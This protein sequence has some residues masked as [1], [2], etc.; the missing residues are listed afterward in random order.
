EEKIYRD[1]GVPCEFVGHP[2]LEEIESII[3]S[4]VINSQKSSMKNNDQCLMTND[5]RTFELRTHFKSALGLDPGKPLLSLLPGSRPHELQRLLPVMID[6]VTRVKGDSGSPLSD[7]QFCMPLAPNTDESKYG[8]LFQ[9]LNDEGVAIKKGESVPVLAASDLAVIASGT[10][11]L[12]AAFLEVPMVVVYKLSPLTFLLGKHI[13][14]VENI[15]LVNILAGRTVVRELLQ[16]AA[17]PE[18]VIKELTKIVSDK[19]HREEMLDHYRTIKR[20]FQG[21][22]ASE[23]VAEI[24]IEMTE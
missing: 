19:R 6:I 11:T 3:K 5:V 21:R 15:S 23:R 17:S 20:P 18:K 22:K 13:V 14:K 10:A 9:R 7:Y 2:V 16:E 1:A 24:V 12:Q 4:T 8:P